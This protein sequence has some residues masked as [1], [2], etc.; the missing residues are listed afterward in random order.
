MDAFSHLSI[1]LSIILGLGIAELLTRFGGIIEHRAGSTLYGP[2]VSWAFLLLIAH[3]QTWWTIFGL[4][5]LHTW[6]FFAFSVVLLQPIALF[7]LSILSLPRVGSDVELKTDLRANY[8]ANRRWYFGL[9]MG[10]LVVSIVKDLV[11][12]GSLPSA[13]N[14]GFH[15]VLFTV[16]LLGIVTTRDGVHRLL[17][18]GSLLAIGAYIAAL[19]SRLP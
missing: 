10:L 13:V 18:Y 4:R 8:F 15:G 14:L 11:L 5:E 6:T 17:A 16:A 1:L 12:S 3:V 19:F 9:F 2:A 7:L